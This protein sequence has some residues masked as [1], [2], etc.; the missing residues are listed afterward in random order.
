[1]R[2]LREDIR[3]NTNRWNETTARAEQGKLQAAIDRIESELLA[4]ARRGSQRRRDV[5]ALDAQAAT[6]P[7]ST[8]QDPARRKLRRWHIVAAA[9]A[10]MLAVFLGGYIY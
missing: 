9:A 5:H 1:M 10:A 6:P 2:M 4:G 8:G 7:T 3:A